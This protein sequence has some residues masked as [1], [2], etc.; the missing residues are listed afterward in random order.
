MIPL[1]IMGICLISP[2]GRIFHFN[3][4]SINMVLGF[5]ILVYGVAT[6]RIFYGFKV[7]HY[8]FFLFFFN[9]LATLATLYHSGFDEDLNHALKYFYYGFV[10]LIC[11]SIPITDKKV[12]RALVIYFIS[13]FLMCIV[14]LVDYYNIFKVPGFNTW[15]DGA[16]ARTLSNTLGVSGPF[17]TRTGIANYLCISVPIGVHCFFT[18]TGRSRYFYAFASL[19]VVLTCLLSLSRG[20]YPSILCTFLLYTFRFYKTQSAARATIYWRS[21]FLLVILVFGS[22]YLIRQS[23]QLHS[24]LMT[25]VTSLD[26]EQ[27]TSSDADMLRVWA[28]QQTVRDLMESPF[29]M[30]YSTVLLWTGERKNPHNVFTM[31]LR[32]AGFLGVI[33]IVSFITPYIK[34]SWTRKDDP[35]LS[36]LNTVFISFLLYGMTHHIL[37]TL[38]FWI[39]LGLAINKLFHPQHRSEQ[40]AP[41]KPRFKV[42]MRPAL[43]IVNR[44]HE[45]QT[46]QQPVPV[47]PRPPLEFT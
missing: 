39:F 11:S 40:E 23:S 34:R 41:W 46:Q 13:S 43:P 35:V 19:V 21:L 4:L 47:R 38:L 17:E 5:G 8:M 45:P 33:F 2:W 16:M 30:G 29:G 31:L 37:G 10:T 44:P 18:R 26:V 32:V 15:M 28:F 20:L 25:R 6:G 36:C 22:Y 24:T 7:Y 9:L 3:A 42:V 12:D 1:L 14:S 27:V